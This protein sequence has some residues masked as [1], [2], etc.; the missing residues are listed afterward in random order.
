MA[1]N[2]AYHVISRNNGWVVKREGASKAAGVFSTKN[3]AERASDKFRDKS[4]DVIV[5]KAD[6]TISE[7]KR[8]R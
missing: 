7:W 3:D 5:H 8:G 2:N 1:R 6:G 4:Y